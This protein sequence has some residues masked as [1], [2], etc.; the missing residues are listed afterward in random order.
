MVVLF[1]QERLKVKCQI[2]FHI[3]KCFVQFLP[4]ASV[5]ISKCKLE[6]NEIRYFVVSAAQCLLNLKTPK[7]LH[8]LD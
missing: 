8:S 3:R 6:F 1:V 5:L 7:M 4:L 2:V